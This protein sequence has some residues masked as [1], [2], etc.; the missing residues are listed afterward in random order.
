[1]EFLPASNQIQ[2][3]T[4]SPTL[5]QYNTASSSQFNLSY[6][7]RDTNYHAIDTKSNV[8]SGSSVSTTWANLE[9][10]TQYQW[11]ATINDGDS[12]TTG[13]LWSFT[14]VDPAVPIQLA[15][16]TAAIEQNSQNVLVRWS[17][18]SEVNNYGFYVQRRNGNEPSFK[19]IEN[20]FTTGNGTTLEPQSYSF[21]DNTI[22]TPAIYH[23]RLRQ[24]DNDGLEHFTIS[25]SINFSILAV[26]ESVP[27]EFR[28]YQNYPNPFNPT[29]KLKFSLEKSGYTT[30]KVYNILGQVVANLFESNAE[31]GKLYIV[32][33]NASASGGL[34]SG[35]YFYRLETRSVSDQYKS[36]TQVRKLLLLR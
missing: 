23:Y 18:I 8:L 33:F 34:T 24:L 21:N 15:S 32:N 2:V 13:P 31:A 35:V 6:S 17:T 5:D 10:L 20:S 14:T 30:L 12:T 16:L 28:L 27:L 7:M 1:M 3:K 19:D 11:Y 36:F 26:T 22:V 4:Y 25:V 29:T 9:R